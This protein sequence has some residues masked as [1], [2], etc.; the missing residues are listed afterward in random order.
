[1][2]LNGEQPVEQQP[3]MQKIQIYSTSS[4]GVSPFWRGLSL[5]SLSSAHALS[6]ISHLTLLHSRREV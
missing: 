4:T 6:H 5:L 3:E 2:A 1:M